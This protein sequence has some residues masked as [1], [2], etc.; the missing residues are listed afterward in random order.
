MKIYLD[1]KFVDSADAKISVF[2]H[3]LLY[4][5][6]V[7]EGIRLYGGNIFRL[8]E[9]LERLEYSAKA[10]MLDLPLTRQEFSDITCEACRQNGLTD[11]YIRLVVTRGVGDLGLSPWTCPKPSVF[12]IASKISLYPQ[13]HYDNGLAIVTVPTRRINAAALPP[14]VK[15][16]NYLNNILGKIEAKQFGALEAIMLNDQGYV[17]ECTADN[18]FIVHK[19]EIITPGA[20]Q[21][22]LKGIT[23]S[24]IFDIAAELKI[25]IRES[26][27]T[28][29]D[30]WCADECFLTGSGAEVVPAVKLDGRVIGSGKPGPITQQVLASFRRRVLVEG[31][32]I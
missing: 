13:E 16:L 6:G 26:N 4:G 15:S 28:R 30:V 20:S 2:D 22:A 27:M 25:P 18:I 8:E 11:G 10:I 17:A 21:G 24:S 12:V 23:R 31:T 1:G 29:Y 19:G 5:D 32:K 7:F 9:H 14:T 3:G